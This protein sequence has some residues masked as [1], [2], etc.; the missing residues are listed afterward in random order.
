MSIRDWFL[1][2]QPEALKLH[3]ESTTK[4]I[5]PKVPVLPYDTAS[6]SNYATRSEIVYSCIEKKAQSACDP[7]LIIQK[8]TK[9]G[10]W[11]TVESHPAL[12]TLLEPNPWDDG[13]SFMRT[14]IASEN[15]SGEFYA[16]IVRSRVGVPV[17]FYPLRPDC[18]FPQYVSRGGFDVL[19]YYAY[20]INGREIRYKPEDLLIRRRHGLGSLYSG[21][22]PLY[23]ALGAVDADI[24][25]TEYIRAFFN[26]GG[27]PSGIINVTGR[28]LS[29]E[30]M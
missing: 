8:K 9:G 6:L 28:N 15:I 2:T 17:E 24:A 20:R 16:E 22:S 3:A 7:E 27:T 18:I 10:E 29:D 21:V 19:D 14:W 13:E 26:N 4:H 23:V 30:E 11:E 1:G 25:S 5:I 12:E